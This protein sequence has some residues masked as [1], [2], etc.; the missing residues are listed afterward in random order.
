MGLVKRA[1][2][3][4]KLVDVTRSYARDIAASCSPGSMA[5]IKR[6][7][8]GGLE[9]GMEAARRE[10]V[11]LLQEERLVED[12]AGGTARYAEKRSPRFAGIGVDLSRT[13]VRDGR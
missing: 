3:R 9:I 11:H 13:V 4:E 10:G 2:P 6:Q 8:Y 7:L 5:Q 12:F 1:V